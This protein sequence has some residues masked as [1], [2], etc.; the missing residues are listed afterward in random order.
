MSVGDDKVPVVCPH[1]NKRLRVPTS[2]I[3]KHGR[4]PQC[5]NVFPLEEEVFEAEPV[6]PA[7][8]FASS[9]DSPNPFSNSPAA[10][11]SSGKASESFE[12]DYQVEPAQPT[13]TQSAFPTATTYA[14]SHPAQLSKKGDFWN[15]SVLGGIALMLI[16]VVWFV[17]G[18]LLIDRIFIYPPIMFVI[19]I[20]TTVKG[21]MSGNLAGE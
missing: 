7:T 18:L 14:A 12:G 19:G 11:S 3:G 10:A 2:A 13:V 9:Y 16:A 21:L 6:A 8:T 4:C 15:S 20:V 5:S 17:A 1:C